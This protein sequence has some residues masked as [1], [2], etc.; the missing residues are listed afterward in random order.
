M[1]QQI[2][3]L[4]THTVIYGIGDSL[5]RLM[6]FLLLPLYTRRLTPADYGELELALVILSLST[7]VAMQGLRNAFFRH[8]TAADDPQ[9][10]ETLLGSS[11]YYIA[12]SSAALFGLLYL[13]SGTLAQ[14]VFT[15]GRSAAFFVRMVAVIGFFEAVYL[16]PL[17]SFRANLQPV[18]YIAILLAGFLV[19]TGLNI[20]LVAVL[21]M[22]VRGVLV[23]Y[24]AGAALIAV[25]AVGLARRRLRPRISGA[26][27]RELLAFG[28]PLIPVGIAW[29][30]LGVSNRVLLERLA[31]SRDVG[32]YSLGYRFANILTFVVITPFSTAWGP[33]YIRI[34]AGERPGETFNTVA[35]TLLF[36]L[37]LVGLGLIVFTEPVIRIMAAPAF[38]S[39][40]HVVFPL[41]LAGVASGMM[42]IFDVG[43]NVAK[44]T[45]HFVYIIGAGGLVNVGLNWLLIPAFGTI[46]AGFS[47]ALAYLT[48][49]A[50]TYR[51]SQR[52]YPI[53]YDTG[54][55]LRLA[56]LFA[57]VGVG[58]QLL[59]VDSI[60][61]NLALRAALM[62][63]FVGGLF[64]LGIVREGERARLR[65]LCEQVRRRPGLL[66]KLR[67]TYD[68]LRVG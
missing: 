27:L 39:A 30:V 26:R 11:F 10:R 49:M 40:Y 3:R 65:R 59:S 55:M 5:K 43:I 4:G 50:L 48:T 25:L 62:A 2:A 46:G 64:W 19:Q 16:I 42:S 8:Y 54:R 6:G 44:K 14:L 37:C 13:F 1:R 68:L 24:I 23:G 67:Y 45:R 15:Q 12:L 17:E 63:L 29:W 60:L 58:S 18:H 9:E 21:S 41:V 51:V 28:L 47:L 33:Y 57:A 52:L 53:P 61:G 66:A 7:T 20:Y 35:T 36:V 34:A 38:W 56:G 31:S 22:G 32:L